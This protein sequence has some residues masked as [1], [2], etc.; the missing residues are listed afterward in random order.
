MDYRT[1]EEMM[2]RLPAAPWVTE[3]IEFYNIHGYY[4]AEDLRKL[5]G[6]PCRGVSAS[7]FEEEFKRKLK[8]ELVA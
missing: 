1:F 4:R 7:T 8:E 6:D 5:L 3:M 2:Q